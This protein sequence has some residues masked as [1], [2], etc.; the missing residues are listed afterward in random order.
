MLSFVFDR[1]I[2]L[3]PLKFTPSY[4]SISFSHLLNWHQ[5][6]WHVFDH[7]SHSK[8]TLPHFPQ[9]PTLFI[10]SILSWRIRSL[11]VP[12][13]REVN[14]KIPK[15]FESVSGSKAPLTSMELHQFT[16]A[17]DLSW[18]LILHSS[19]IWLGFILEAQRETCSETR[20][21][22]EGRVEEGGYH[23]ER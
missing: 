6:F 9:L 2:H 21:L 22:A 19:P 12:K 5:L 10:L 20:V 1:K 13:P 23:L 11:A 7:S 18:C 8:R 4:F 16:P 14:E 15:G 17:E 3:L